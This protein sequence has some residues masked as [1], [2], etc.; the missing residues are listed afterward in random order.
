MEKIES[1]KAEYNICTHG[2]TNANQ[3]NVGTGTYT[4]NAL[5]TAVR[6]E[7]IATDKFC[8]HYTRECVA[9]FRALEWIQQLRNRSW[10][11]H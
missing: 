10:M 6:E 5:G 8:S 9:F 2:L 11:D 7:R 4:N 1:I 3:E